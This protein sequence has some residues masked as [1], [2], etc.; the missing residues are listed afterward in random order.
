MNWFHEIDLYC[1][2][3]GPGFFEEPFNAASNLGFVLAAWL[4]WRKGRGRTWDFRVLAYLIA[5]VG[6]CSL[7]FHTF[8]TRWA[9]ALDT[10]AIALFTWFF[11]QRLLVRAVGFGNI[12][13][14]LMVMSYAVT[15][16]MVERYFTAEWL[17]GSIAYV[18]PLAVLGGISVSLVATKGALGAPF[19]IA[20][21][22]FGLSLALRTIDL[23]VCHIFQAGTHFMWHLLN[24][25][26]LYALGIGLAGFVSR[27]SSRRSTG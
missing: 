24:A 17:N 1:E 13:A 27:R 11:L 12:N 22:L 18:P 2:R 7:A 25:A 15:A 20:T 26:V 10:A 8:A 23:A 21:I 6:I 16:Y 19:I 14:A 4:V 3:T 9:A 5:L